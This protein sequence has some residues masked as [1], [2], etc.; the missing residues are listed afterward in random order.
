MQ[1]LAALTRVLRGDRKE[2]DLGGF[3]S[4]RQLLEQE[5]QSELTCENGHLLCVLSP[6]FGH[7]G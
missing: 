2:A 4:G 7:Q 6:H 3:R 1:G 5:G